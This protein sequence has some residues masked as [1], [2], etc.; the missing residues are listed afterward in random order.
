MKH[1]CRHIDALS[2]PIADEDRADGFEKEK[3]LPDPVG[4]SSSAE[5]VSTLS[6]GSVGYASTSLAG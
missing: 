2:W 4:Y 6:E 5:D 3:E 1:P